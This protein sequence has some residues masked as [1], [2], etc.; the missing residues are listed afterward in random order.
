MIISLIEK[1][2]YS[3][4]VLFL[5]CQQKSII[6]W[7]TSTPASARCSPPRSLT[8][9]LTSH[10]TWAAR[11]ALFLT[12]LLV[13]AGLDGSAR[14]KAS[15]FITAAHPFHPIASAHTLLTPHTYLHLQSPC[16]KITGGNKMR[17]VVWASHKYISSLDLQVSSNCWTAVAKL[18]QVKSSL[19]FKQVMTASPNSS[20]TILLSHKILNFSDINRQE[21]SWWSLS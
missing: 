16:K 9:L 18:K 2:A 20:E 5:S 14:P 15:T 1:P 3:T 11:P 8:P 10:S 19:N 17:T 7:S 6:T 12:R 13:I 21:L 4:K